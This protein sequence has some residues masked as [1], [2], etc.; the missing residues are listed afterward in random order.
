MNNL[1]IEKFQIA[2]KEIAERYG[3]NQINFDVCK[4]NRN[5]IIKIDS[6]FKN[7]EKIK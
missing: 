4:G 7:T 2:V 3:L 6:S 5:I 1:Q